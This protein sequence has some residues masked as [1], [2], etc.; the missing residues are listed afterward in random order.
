MDKG[1]LAITGVGLAM[2]I[3]VII[4]AALYYKQNHEEQPRP[5]H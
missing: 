2:L 3:Y 4:H 1:T 5:K